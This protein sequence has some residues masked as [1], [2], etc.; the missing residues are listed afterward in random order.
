MGYDDAELLIRLKSAVATYAQ[1]KKLFSALSAALQRL[2][3]Q[4]PDLG[5]VIEQSTDRSIRF[6]YLDRP[7][8]MVLSMIAQQSSRGL[9]SL[10]AIKPDTEP[11]VRQEIA[12][13]FIDSL[14]NA[15]EQLNAK[16]SDL[17]IQSDP[18]TVCLRWLVRL[19]K[20]YEGDFP[21][22]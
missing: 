22:G 14:G 9:V 20:S 10:V 4:E 8:E 15:K 3:N 13:L 7:A 6:R 1:L 5:L 16:T 19:L 11:E 12:R 2:V 18:T 21:S 17:N